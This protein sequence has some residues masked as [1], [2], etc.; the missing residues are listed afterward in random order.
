M[1]NVLSIIVTYNFEPWLDKC[2]SSLLHSSY[3][4]DLIIIDN[5][6]QDNTVDLIRR[7]FPQVTLVE[8]AVNLGFG[9]ANNIGFQYALDH[10]YDFVFLVNQDAWIHHDCLGHLMTR[11]YPDNIGIISPMHYDGTEQVLDKG[12]ADYIKQIDMTSNITTSPFINA[13]FWL[14]PIT[15][16]KQLGGFSP[17]FYH[18]GED[19]DYVHRLHSHAYKI[20]INPEA[21]SYH[22]RQ[23][24]VVKKSGKSYFK[25]EFTYF[26]TEYANINYNFPKA[27]AY[28]FLGAL[29]KAFQTLFKDQGAFLAYLDVS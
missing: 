25:S 18:Y 13:A 23:N 15:T 4:T 17:L 5:A 7:N 8:S 2:L 24:R 20:A 10:N 12:F 21:I 16:I 9:K 29:K 3:P 19:S 11:Y 27:F 14:I 26:L 1:K 22:D 28:A 6:S